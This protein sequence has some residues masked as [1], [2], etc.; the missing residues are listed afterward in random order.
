MQFEVAG[1]S[2]RMAQFKSANVSRGDQLTLVLEPT[3]EFDALAI[4]V[5]KD[6]QHVGY[7]PRTHN[8]DR[9]LHSALREHPELI[10]CHVDAVWSKGCW[11][12]VTIKDTPEKSSP[13]SANEP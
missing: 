2:Y 9:A 8:R 3:N 6:A 4:K 13:Q 11:A 7:V 1:V 12:A 5:L 10:E